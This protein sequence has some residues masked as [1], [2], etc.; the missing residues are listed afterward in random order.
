RNSHHRAR[1]R[2]GQAAVRSRRRATGGVPLH[3]RAVPRLLLDRGAHVRAR[4]APRAPW[5]LPRA[6][7]RDRWTVVAGIR[8]RARGRIVELLLRRVHRGAGRPARARD[9]PLARRG[10][11]PRLDRPGRVAVRAVAA[12]DA[13]RGGELDEPL[14]RPDDARSRAVVDLAGAPD[15]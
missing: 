8:R 1:V 10:R 3:G 11:L 6:P 14:D 5:A 2:Y 7:R 4:R 12:D 15:W 13:R 9:A